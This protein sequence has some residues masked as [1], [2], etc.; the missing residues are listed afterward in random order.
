[1]LKEENP[2][3]TILACVPTPLPDNPDRSNCEDCNKDQEKNDRFHACLRSF[4]GS[5]M[6]RAKRSPGCASPKNINW[7]IRIGHYRRRMR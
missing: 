3:A 6:R 2:A 4:K 5:A 1:M 7:S